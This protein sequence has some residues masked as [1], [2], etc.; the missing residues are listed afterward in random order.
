MAEIVVKVNLKNQAQ[1]LSRRTTPDHH[2][3]SLVIGDSD[4]NVVFLQKLT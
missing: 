4:N 1:L 2:Y 3:V